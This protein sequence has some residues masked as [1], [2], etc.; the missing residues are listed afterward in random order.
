MRYIRRILAKKD[1]FCSVAFCQICDTN[2]HAA[3]V[4]TVYHRPDAILTKQVFF[5]KWMLLM[6]FILFSAST[7]F[8]KPCISMLN[9]MVVLPIGAT[10]MD[11]SKQKLGI[12]G[13]WVILVLKMYQRETILT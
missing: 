12:K 7:S 1:L 5:L 3:H 6:Y 11:N 4:Q 2:S 8:R 9:K 10:T 13:K